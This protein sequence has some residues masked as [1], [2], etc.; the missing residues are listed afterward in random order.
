M[1]ETSGSTV[2]SNSE[3]GKEKLLIRE[4]GEDLEADFELDEDFSPPVPFEQ[5]PSIESRKMVCQGWSYF[6]FSS[7]GRW[8]LEQKFYWSLGPRTKI[9]DRFGF[10]SL[11]Q[12]TTSCNV[13]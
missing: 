12:A 7:I 13:T 11:G 5:R 8:A 3:N 4:D 1:Q 6:A 10:S 2:S 9:H